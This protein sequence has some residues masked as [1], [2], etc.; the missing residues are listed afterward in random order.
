MIYNSDQIKHT[1]STI[2]H[3]Q[4]D[5]VAAEIL[6]S[7]RAEIAHVGEDFSTDIYRLDLRI[8]AIRFAQI[9]RVAKEV[10]R[11]EEKIRDKLW[12]LGVD[13]EGSVLS[14]VRLLPEMSVGPGAT[15]TAF[16]TATDENRIWRKNRLRLFFS[17]VSRVKVE[18]SALKAALCPYG[19]DA[20]LAHEDIEANADWRR[21]VEYAL[22]SM[23]GLCALITP[24]Y[25]E[26]EWC[27][28]EAGYALGRAVPML[29]VNWGHAPYGLIGKQ[30]AIKGNLS[31]EE[32]A[33]KIFDVLCKEGPL[34][35]VLMEGLVRA[36]VLAPTYASAR[37]SIK[38]LVIMDKHLTKDQVLRLLVAAKDNSQVS[39]ATN[40]SRQIDGIAKRAQVAL[41][42]AKVA[43]E[44]FDDDIPS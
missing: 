16:P 7:A 43:A 2:L 32:C 29:S 44:E 19:I 1:L 10:Q 30:Q 17:Y 15:S 26:S 33:A 22:R 27:D 3:A 21:D 39:E 37:T 24:D 25:H 14:Q 4:G 6:D 38:R 35:T 5:A 20:F 11:I 13:P 31:S 18:A 8:P 42:P 23:H 36:L 40:V 34:I 9:D 28:Q 41:P 12:K